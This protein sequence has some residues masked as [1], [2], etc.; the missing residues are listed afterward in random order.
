MNAKYKSKLAILYLIIYAV[1]LSLF[2]YVNYI[3]F[4]VI[5]TVYMPI[6]GVSMLAILLDYILFGQV[7]LIASL[8][9]LIA[10]YTIHIKQGIE[11]TMAGAFTNN[12]I[13]MLGFIVGFITQMY[14]KIKKKSSK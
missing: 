11:P 6:L 5:R 4:T 12:T 13:I 14:M 7:F 3:D 9:G 8:L 2:Y 10:E 1:V